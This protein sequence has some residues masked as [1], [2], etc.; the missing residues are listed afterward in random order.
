M[1]AKTS[2]C[3]ECGH[4]SLDSSGGVSG[5]AAMRPTIS[6]AWATSFCPPS[7]HWL[8]A[9][10]ADCGLTRF[11]ASPEAPGKITKSD[12]WRKV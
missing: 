12:K 11:F 8:F 10:I 2:N 3:P 1:T 4:S 7:S 6:R 5:A 9:R